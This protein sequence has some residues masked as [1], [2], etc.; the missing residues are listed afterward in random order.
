MPPGPDPNV[1]LSRLAYEQATHA[2]AQQQQLL[3]GL[4]GRAGTLLSA[5]AISTSFLGGEALAAGPVRATTWIA[6]CCFVVV[7]MTSTAILWPRLAI[8]M[9][10]RPLATR[11]TPE[12]GHAARPIAA[13]LLMLTDHLNASY[14]RNEPHIARVAAYLRTGVVFLTLEVVWW[15]ADL[16]VRA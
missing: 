5:A 6:T 7:G 15:V 11:G 14:A 9:A 10:T 2:L 3:D 8:E 12:G 4:R 13:T 1:A 16:A